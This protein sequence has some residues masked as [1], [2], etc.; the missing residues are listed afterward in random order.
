MVRCKHAHCCCLCL[1]CTE[2][3]VQHDCFTCVAPTYKLGYSC[4]HIF[5]SF[6]LQNIMRQPTELS[7]EVVRKSI[8]GVDNFL[9]SEDDENTAAQ[10]VVR[11]TAVEVGT[12]FRD[13]LYA[14]IH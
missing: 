2:A 14:T 9:R 12:H 5:R 3:L 4:R 11:H 6:C 10:G 8:V 13:T 1:P 7:E